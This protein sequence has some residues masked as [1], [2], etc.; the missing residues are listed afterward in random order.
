MEIF[1][2][3]EICVRTNVRIVKAPAPRQ[4]IKAVCGSFL[5]FGLHQKVE[6]CNHVNDNSL[7]H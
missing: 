7:T 6:H 3:N 5:M 1:L 4:S 2:Q